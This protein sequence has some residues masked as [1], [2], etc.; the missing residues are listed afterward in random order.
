MPD[1]TSDHDL[2]AWL[3]G[4]AGERLLHVRASSGL[5]GAELK[6]AGDEAA[7]EVLAGLLSAFAP[8]DAVLSEE[9]ADSAARLSVDR[10]WI[11][12]PLD[13]TREFSEPPRDDWAV[14]VA[15]WERDR[16]LTAGAVALPARDQVFHT[17]PGGFEAR[18]ARTSTVGGADEPLRL[19][20][21]RSRPPAFVTPLQEA[22]GADLV[23]MGSAGVKVI[24]VVDGTTDLYVHAGGQYEW[25]SAAPVAVA[26]AAGLFTSRVDGSELEYN[27]ESPYLPDLVVCRPELADRVLEI[28]SGL[29]L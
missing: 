11:I 8:T 15:L 18:S 29:E 3:A 7:Q 1:F 20:V 2:A 25:D 22:L 27:R 10:V 9:A 14:H 6:D 17:G 26:R 4:Q 24:S 16:G 12:D 23:P 28:L 13:G 5:E 19:A 21:S